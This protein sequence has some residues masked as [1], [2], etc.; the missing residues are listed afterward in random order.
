MSVEIGQSFTEISNFKKCSTNDI[1]R[2]RGEEVYPSLPSHSSE[3]LLNSINAALAKYAVV[4]MTPT[5]RCSQFSA[6]ESSQSSLN[7][8]SPMNQATCF[9]VWRTRGVNNDNFK[10]NFR[11]FINSHNPCFV[12]L[13]QTK[14]SNHLGLM[15]D[16]DF[17]DYWEVPLGWDCPPVAHFTSFVS[18]TRKRQMSRVGLSSSGTLLLSVLLVSVRRLRNYMQ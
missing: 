4:V 7:P 1:S 15:Y 14:L 6:S 17:D 9:I 18:I 16:F 13:L 3:E 8:F 10:M 11:D 12:A 2:K 5:L